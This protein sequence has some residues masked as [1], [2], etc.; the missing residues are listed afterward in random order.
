LKARAGR[1]LDTL[2][3]GNDRAYGDLVK[4]YQGY[5]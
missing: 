2:R 3:S 1:L 5:P 4:K